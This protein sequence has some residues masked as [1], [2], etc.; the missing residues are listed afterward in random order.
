MG[1]S[2]RGSLP[3]VLQGEEILFDLDPGKIWIGGLKLMYV[4]DA[5]AVRA[6]NGN[7][8][9]ER[10]R[11]AQLTSQ[12]NSVHVIGTSFNYYA[13]DGHW[14]TV[15][16]NRAPF[17]VA[18]SHPGSYW[19]QNEMFAFVGDDDQAHEV[20]GATMST[21]TETMREEKVEKLES[22]LDAIDA[23]LQSKESR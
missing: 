4:S 21:A 3:L 10:T 2:Q 5:D 13:E 7:R 8:I 17:Q 1:G 22:G 19:V 9:T 15:G 18:I 23:F 11:I 12:K 6:I 16:S 20:Q 14:Y